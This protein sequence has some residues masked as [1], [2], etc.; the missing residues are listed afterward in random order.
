MIAAT[1]PRATSRRLVLIGATSFALLSACRG[2][3]DGP[4]RAGAASADSAARAESYGDVVIAPPTAADRAV[5]VAT[6]GTVSGTV[7]LKEPLPVLPAVATGAASGL[8]GDSIADGSAQVQGSGL[9]GAV[10]WLDG[11]RSGKALGLE[12]RLELESDHCRLTPR[13]QAAM[14]GSA[15]NIIGHDEFR[16]HLRFT[17]GGETVPRAAILLGGGEQVIPTE[18]PFKLPG[19]VAVRDPDHAWTRAYLAVFDHPYYA[20]SGTGGAFTI[21]GVPPGHYTLHAWHERTG[22]T[23]QSVDVAADGTVKV[24]VVLAGKQP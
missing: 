18:L 1:I 9:A 6:P 8:C 23:T 15:V 7:T 11:I 16:Q 17:S 19:M 22:P 4:R 5:T 24:A 14:V 12:R 20:V 2:D 10:V 21:D 3:A 13:V